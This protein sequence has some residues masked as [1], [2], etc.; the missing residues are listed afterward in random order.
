MRGVESTTPAVVLGAGIGA[1]GIMRSLGPLGVRVACVDPNPDALPFRSRYCRE[2]IVSSRVE[3]EPDA[4]LKMLVEL[5]DRLGPKP[6]LYWT[7][8]EL[9]LFCAGHADVLRRH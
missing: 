6:I 7:S 1:L 9:A 3:E 5:S 2:K 8:D 4:F